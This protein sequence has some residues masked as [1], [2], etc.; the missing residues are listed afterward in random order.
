[1]RT[2][3]LGEIGFTGLRVADAPFSVRVGRLGLALVEEAA[4]GLQLGV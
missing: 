1:M 3:P 4:D 2:A